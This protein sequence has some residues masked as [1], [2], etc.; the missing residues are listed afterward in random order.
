MRFEEL[1]K[2]YPKFVYQ[3]YSY[4]ISDRNLEIFFEF[5]IGSEFIF[6][7]KITIENIDKKRLEGIKIETLDNLVFNLGMIEALSYWKAT[8][9]PLIEIKCGFLNAGQVKWWKDLMEKGLGQFF[10]ENK[11]DF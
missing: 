9:S 11:I 1:R 10:Y 5:R 8:C 7:P 4:R 6:N 2:K 3:G